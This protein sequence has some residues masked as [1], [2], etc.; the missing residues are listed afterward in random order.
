MEVGNFD[1]N[2]VAPFSMNKKT[3]G[4]ELMV[5]T[6]IYVKEVLPALNT[7]HV[8]ALA[9][10]TG[11]GMWENVPRILPPELT[12]ELQGKFINILPIFGW[13]TSTGCVEK[14]DIMKIFNCGV[15]MILIASPEAQLPLLKSLHGSSASVIGKVIPTK[16][17]G[18]QLI[19]RHFA[20][21][22]ELVERLLTTPKKRVGVLISGSGSNLQALIDATKNTAMGMC[23]DIVHVAAE[24]IGIICHNSAQRKRLMLKRIQTTTTVAVQ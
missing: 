13:L 9:H 1:V 5:P 14:L 16:P 20:T 11:G 22:V 10:I 21:C 12:A 23:S 15:G 8:K 18:H 4:K 3:F 17:G 7:G 2:D 24:D 6:E 19:I